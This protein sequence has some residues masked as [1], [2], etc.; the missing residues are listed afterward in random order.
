MVS[1]WLLQG[2]W[3]VLAIEAVKARKRERSRRVFCRLA[4]VPHGDWLGSW[5]TVRN[6][7]RLTPVR[8][9]RLGSRFCGM[10]QTRLIGGKILCVISIQHFFNL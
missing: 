6:R 1:S 5:P 8:C 10:E 2:E 9:V 3:C 4:E 7:V